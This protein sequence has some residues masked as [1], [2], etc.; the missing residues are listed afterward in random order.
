[1]NVETAKYFLGQIQKLHGQKSGS[2][3]AILTQ[4]FMEIIEEL[5]AEEGFQFN[6]LFS[7]VA[8][9]GSRY[10][11]KGV[12]LYHLHGLRK[13]LES[14][15]L[16][17]AAVHPEDLVVLTELILACTAIDLPEDYFDYSPLTMPVRKSFSGF[18]A[19]AKVSVQ[20]IDQ[21][22]KTARVIWVDAPD[23]LRIVRF[24]SPGIHDEFYKNILSFAR[25]DLLP[26]MAM[27]HQIRIDHQEV[28][29]PEMI[30]LEPDY[31][32]GVT[33]I[34]ECFQTEGVMIEKYFMSKLLP[35]V[36]SL[37]ILIGFIA[38]FFLDELIKDPDVRFKE[39]FPKT[40]LL[41]PVLMSGLSD[42]DL[43][44]VMAEAQMHFVHLKRVI[45]EDFE[46]VGID[47]SQCLLEPSYYAPSYGIQGRLDLLF[48]R[49]DRTDIVE[50]KSGRPFR[51]N[52]YGLSQNHYV[53]TLLYDIIIKNIK[54]HKI[55]PR[56]YI[57]YSKLSDNAL[58]PAHF[59]KS[60]LQE[61]MVV[62][63]LIILLERLLVQGKAEL[64]FHRISIGRFPHIKGYLADNIAQIEHVYQSIPELERA[65]LAAFVS[66]V[67]REHRMAKLGSDLRDINGLSGLWQ[68]SLAV[69][70][71]RFAILNQLKY[72]GLDQDGILS[73]ARTEHTVELSKFRKGDIV[74]LYAVDDGRE[75]VLES[76]VMKGTLIEMK[77]Q[78]VRLRMRSIPM[79]PD[80]LAAVQYW[81]VEHD[82]IDSQFAQLTRSVFAFVRSVSE[83]RRLI[84]GLEPP[85]R[86]ELREV[87]DRS[88]YASLSEE[89]FDI[90][91]QMIVSK[92]YFLLWG[93][94][95]TGKTSIMLR[96]YVEYHLRETEDQILVLAYT[97]R[98]VDEI[99]QSLSGI[100]GIDFIRVGSRY[101]C[102][103]DWQPHLLNKRIEQH[104]TRKEIIDTISGVR[105]FVSTVSSISG[106]PELLD[107][108]KFDRVVVDE[109]SQI[110]E[111]QLV[112]LLVG[113]DHF[114]LIGDH[115]QLPAVT[116]QPTDRVRTDQKLLLDIGLERLDVSLFERLYKRAQAQSW[117]H[118]YAMLS[119]QGRMHRDVM[120]FSGTHF[121]GGQ[122]RLLDHLEDVH[123]RLCAPWNWS[124]PE[125][126]LSYPDILSKR[127][128]FIHAPLDMAS[129]HLKVNHFEAKIVARVIADLQRVVCTK[130]DYRIGVITPYRAQ[131]ATIKRVLESEQDIHTE[132]LTI[133][134]VERYQGG[135]RDII[136]ISLCINH[137]R[138]LK[139][140]SSSTID[141]VDRKL[142]VALTR[143]REQVIMIGN[144]DMLYGSEPYRKFVESYLV[145]S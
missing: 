71:E 117:T 63:N 16:R 65:Y 84:L 82:L 91:Q 92:D 30:V 26:V 46:R 131:I 67:S 83:R 33:A 94:P 123:Q 15:E 3:G 120:M 32:I 109:A 1:M 8:Y 81:N 144:K 56:C 68:D 11:L 100:D 121:Y 18:L 104:S 90:L 6:T 5:S 34:A 85:G 130:R 143:G 36:N 44:Q 110:L 115:R 129:E 42:A 20:S 29:Y 118:A 74:V 28:W 54:N 22:E 49:S 80:Q 108:K 27:L 93:P 40:F 12:L 112:G 114:V 138:Q 55:K 134:T 41:N 101:A 4:L 59:I 103:E 17:Q 107:L 72:V 70:K 43:R 106:K 87:L 35:K 89:Q 141:G 98:A 135:A 105:V 133:D 142:N 79:N 132:D 125:Y 86:S 60:I 23:E 139:L 75:D 99:C 122:L 19:Q 2:S 113:F 69:K 64:L 145:S 73:L 95:G 62:R 127:M 14:G 96:N 119:Q 25:Y 97:N 9:L 10:Q 128:L 57:L 45:T 37:P 126:E 48:E 13:K 78:I 61:A 76:H 31:L 39:L 140:L 7:R 52:A 47:R 102:A 50:L 21:E 38:N 51:P 124:S 88:R 116:L 136:I 58:R 137:P 24:D 66:F 53:Q 77:G 111:L